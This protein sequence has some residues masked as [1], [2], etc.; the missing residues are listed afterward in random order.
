MVVGEREQLTLNSTT[1]ANTTT[2]NSTTQASLIRPLS[3]SAALLNQQVQTG[4]HHS[5]KARDFPIIIRTLRITL[6]LITNYHSLLGPHNEVILIFLLE[7]LNHPSTSW[8][9]AVAIEVLHK[10]LAQSI[11][12]KF[13]YRNLF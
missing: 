3:V 9:A 7:L 6:A 13:F 2:S 11:L 8:E 10:I 5:S 4:H 12:L 1:G